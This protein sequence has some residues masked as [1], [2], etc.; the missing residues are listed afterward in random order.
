MNSSAP[1]EFSF[2]ISPKSP[3]IHVA[4]RRPFNS[5]KPSAELAMIASS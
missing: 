4:R 2:A 3:A 5:A 1:W